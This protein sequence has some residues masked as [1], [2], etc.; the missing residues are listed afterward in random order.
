MVRAIPIIDKRF[1]GDLDRYV[2]TISTCFKAVCGGFRYV[3]RNQKGEEVLDFMVALGPISW[4]CSF[5]SFLEK[6]LLGF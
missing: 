3:S 4:N 2:D 5:W 6:V 1:I